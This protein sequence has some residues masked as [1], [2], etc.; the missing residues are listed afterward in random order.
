MA[1]SHDTIPS[2]CRS[3]RQPHRLC[4]AVSAVS[5][6]AKAQGYDS[7]QGLEFVVAVRPDAVT[8]IR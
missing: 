8:I 6:L 3:R 7:A 2:S 1:S 5:P 4:R